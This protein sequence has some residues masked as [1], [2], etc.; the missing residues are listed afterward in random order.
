MT[1]FTDFVNS[2]NKIFERSH[3]NTLQADVRITFADFVSSVI[4]Q[5]Q[6]TKEKRERRK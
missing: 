1:T 5:V 2:V 4:Q 6:S 3:D